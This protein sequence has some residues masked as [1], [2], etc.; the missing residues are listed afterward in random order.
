MSN[1]SECVKGKGAS[2]KSPNA[3][4][5]QCSAKGVL[6]ALSQSHLPDEKVPTQNL[7]PT[8]SQ[9]KDHLSSLVRTIYFGQ[10]SAIVT[11]NTRGKQLDSGRQQRGGCQ[12]QG[13]GV[14]RDGMVNGG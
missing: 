5:V 12:G 14:P 11:D 7:Q 1:Q 4:Q 2:Q 6:E 13:N 8:N 3:V 10:Y 9:N